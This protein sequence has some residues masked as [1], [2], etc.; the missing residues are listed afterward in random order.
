[1]IEILCQLKQDMTLVPHTLIDRENLANE[2]KVNQILKT[3][4]TGAE[5]ERSIP[6]NNLFHACCK[7][8]AD[9]FSGISG[10]Q[11]AMR[12]NTLEKVKIQCK[13]DCRFIDG[14]VSTSGNVQALL[15]SLEFK[16]TKQAE[17]HAFIKTAI[18]YM[19]V[20]VLGLPGPD[21]LVRMAKE[22]MHRKRK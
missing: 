7:V 6:E 16:G 9:N 15:K 3:K 5:K 19:A 21:E 14:F 2:Y 1:M 22:R 13:I 12:Y 4:I 10:D 11:F 8:V 20:D 18:Q 17:S